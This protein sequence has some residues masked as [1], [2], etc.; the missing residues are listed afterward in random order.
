MKNLQQITGRKIAIHG[1]G[2]LA[3]Q[4]VYYLEKVEVTINYFLDNHSDEKEFCGYAVYNPEDVDLSDVYIIVAVSNVWTYLAIADQY[5]K[6]GLTEFDDYIYCEWLF[7]KVVLLHGNCHIDIIK[8]YLDSSKKFSHEYCFYPNPIIY[9]NKEKEVKKSILENCDIWIHQD[10]RADNE[11]GYGLSD[12]YMRKYIKPETAE[13]IIPHLY[14]LGTL[15][16]PQSGWNQRNRKI[17][18]GR[19]RMGMFP[20]SDKIID[21]CVAMGMDKKHIIDFCLREDCISAKDI[22]DNFI[23]GIDKIKDREKCWDIKI[24]DFILE[25][26]KKNKLFYDI[27]HPTNIILKEISL[28]IL[29]RVGIDDESIYCDMGLDGHEEPVYPCVTKTLGLMWRSEFIRESKIAKKMVPKMDFEEYIKEY[30]WWC[31]GMN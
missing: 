26:Y 17:N 18:G 31:Y 15:F 21:K 22:E 24:A 14:G 2:L 6:K 9:E 25:N 30:L 20:F 12:E 3:V 29:K 4:L 5:G 23:A 7:K 11:L 10:I 27:G 19:D 13:I 16:Y 28:Q 1:T 8:C